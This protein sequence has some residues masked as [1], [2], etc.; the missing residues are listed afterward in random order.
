MKQT[1]NQRYAAISQ[2]TILYISELL[3]R[4]FFEHRI[5]LLGLFRLEFVMERSWNHNCSP[6]ALILQRLCH[7]RYSAQSL[8]FSSCHGHLKRVSSSWLLMAK[9]PFLVPSLCYCPVLN[10][11]SLKVHT[12][13]AVISW[14]FDVFD[15][16]RYCRAERDWP[17]F[18][19]AKYPGEG[20]T[21]SFHQPFAHC[22]SASLP[23]GCIQRTGQPVDHISLHK[24]SNTFKL[25][26][27]WPVADPL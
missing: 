18:G 2:I 4:S 14:C 24:H 13:H 27:I 22:G 15:A 20:D 11:A 23:A 12:V 5:A 26:I 16:V 6:A 21:V 3:S 9:K 7:F 17:E 1:G 19:G 10:V 8:A 25:F